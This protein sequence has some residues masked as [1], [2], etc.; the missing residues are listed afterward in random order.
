MN[1]DR[2]QVE[3]YSRNR[4]ITVLLLALC[5]SFQAL[6]IYGVALFLPDIRKDLGLSF[7]EGGALSAAL[8]IVYALM[9]IP[10]GYLV[11]RF[12]SRIIFFYGSLGNVVLSLAFGLISSYW[13][14]IAS[15]AV[16]GVFRGL[17]FVSSLTLL[18]SW[19]SQSRRATA[20]GLSTIGVFTGQLLVNGLGPILA[21][22]ANWRLPFIVFSAM[23]VV[24]S[25]AFLRFVKESPHTVLTQKVSLLEMSQVLRY[26]SIWLCCGIQ[27]VRHALF[28]GIGFWLPSLLIEEKGLALQMVGAIMAIRAGVLVPSNLMGGFVSD[29]LRNPVQVIGISLVILLITTSL[30]VRV[31]NIALLIVIILVNAFFAQ[32]YFGS[33]FAIPVAILGNRMAGTAIGF[34]N[35]FANLGSFTAAYLLGVLKDTSG[36]FES[37]FDTMA[38]M[39]IVGLIFTVLLARIKPKAVQAAGYDVMG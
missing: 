17:L 7:T 3:S 30:L 11:D 12:G 19:F 10:A 2:H 24:V 6:A 37:G 26:R 32:F 15:Q 4:I 31:D 39:C 14:G 36:S 29:K 28:I 33:V 38:A 22:I 16:S 27:Y 18:A 9:Q 1:S 13:Q 20:I 5:L 21:G 8:T 35:V 25:L 23:G 34:T